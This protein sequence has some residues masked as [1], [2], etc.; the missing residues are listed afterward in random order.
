MNAHA[1]GSN[2]AAPQI[3]PA[4]LEALGEFLRRPSASIAPEVG[5]ALLD[6]LPERPSEEELGSL[7]PAIDRYVFD[8]AMARLRPA[9]SAAWH[10]ALAPDRAMRLPAMIALATPERLDAFGTCA[11]AAALHVPIA[12]NVTKAA[13]DRIRRLLTAEAAEL[14]F[15]EAQFFYPELATVCDAER[16]H[17]D[18]LAR[19][20][21]EARRG[22][23]DFGAALVEELVNGA[24]PVWGALLQFRRPARH[25][26]VPAFSLGPVHREMLF[27]IWERK[28]PNRRSI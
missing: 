21:D 7:A 25:G 16:V 13:A 5:D 18:I 10:A 15:G 17:A 27:R 12:R 2:D 14:A 4:V 9:S 8:C 28:W 24:G 6:L 20:D 1:R 23:T 26:A 3:D 19:S 22:I 11:A